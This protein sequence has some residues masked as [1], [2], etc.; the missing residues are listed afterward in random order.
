MANSRRWKPLVALLLLIG[1]WWLLPVTLQRWLQLSFAEF[2]APFTVAHSH[3]KDLRTYWA[4]Q[5]HS[6]RDL[7]E[8]NRDLS[9]VNAAYAVGLAQ[10][11]E[12]EAEIERLERLLKLPSELEYR[13][14]VARVARRDFTAWWEHVIIRKGRT[15]GIEAGQAVIYAGGV[16]GRVRDVYAYTAVVELVSSP[17]F[18]MAAQ[19]EGTES[20]VTFQGDVNA[21]MQP[22]LG[23]VLNVPPNVKR[24]S[25][26]PLRLLSSELGGIFPAGL[27]IG[28]ITRLEPA[29]DGYFQRGEVQLP[30]RLSELREVAI[31]VPYQAENE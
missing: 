20:P 2:E 25:G 30:Q 4:Y 19:I 8:A 18:R 6:K 17:G 7:I 15:H 11:D 13:Y 22:P 1:L 16:A 3:L 9:R 12:L 14:E 21:P 31:I 23:E 28:D 24:V 10:V 29:V 5:N 27:L 26:K